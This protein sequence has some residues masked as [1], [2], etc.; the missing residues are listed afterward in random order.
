MKLQETFCS[1][2]FK[3][4]ETSGLSSVSKI[5]DNLLSTNDFRL[6]YGSLKLIV[7][8]YLYRFFFLHFLNII[9][10]SK[11]ITVSFITSAACDFMSSALTAEE[12][13]S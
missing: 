4:G 5:V 2:R 9:N 8:R 3:V 11:L 1:S 12:K 10:T 13:R 6:F 7:A